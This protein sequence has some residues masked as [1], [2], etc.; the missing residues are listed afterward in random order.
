MPLATLQALTVHPAADAFPYIS[1]EEI[2]SLAQD[3]ESNGLV[4]PIVLFENEIL[5]GRNRL[6]ALA[7]TNLTSVPVTEYAGTDP[8]GYV[9]S[10]N[11]H[12]RH[13]S[14]HDWVEVGYKLRDAIVSRQGQRTDL[15][16]SCV[17]TQEV[18][19]GKHVAVAKA[20]EGAVS[21]STLHK[22]WRVM[23]D[24]PE[25]WAEAKRTKA[26]IDPTYRKMV[27]QPR[28][29]R[30]IVERTDSQG[31]TERVAVRREAMFLDVLEQIANKLVDAKELA[32]AFMAGA[33]EA[34]TMTAHKLATRIAKLATDLETGL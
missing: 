20:L 29:D 19:D 16:T 34:D 23:E 22:G 27:A 33:N 6:R 8:V 9:L 17:P 21:A 11:V 24:A 30:V 12:R 3:I 31:R 4:H 25:A 10:V 28:D 1:D 5:D 13:L 7:K 18:L 26:G 15:T 32:D 14:A 2:M